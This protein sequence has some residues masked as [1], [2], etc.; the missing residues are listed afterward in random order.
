MRH[1]RD[2]SQMKPTPIAHRS[3]AVFHLP[4]QV[5]VLITFAQA[6]VTAMTGNKFFPTPVP[7]LAQ[8]T[9]A[10]ADLVTAQTAAQS[11]THGAVVVRNEKRLALVTELEQLKSY[12]QN[13]A[14]ADREQASGIIQS[15]S[16]SVRKVPVRARA[17]FTAKPGPASGSVLLRT[18]SAGSR[19]TYAWEVS[20]DGGVTWQAVASTVQTKTTVIGLKAGASYS[21]RFRAV[22][23]AGLGDWSQP[24]SLIVK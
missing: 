2:P 15:A 21:F 1:R 24:V 20:A 11:R 16:L 12:V 23:K 10:I 22:T 14:D 4:K 8:I 13:I 18:P 19:A 5:P 17:T 7:S 6:I 3:I 9:Q